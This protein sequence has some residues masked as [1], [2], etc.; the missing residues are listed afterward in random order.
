MK[1]VALCLSGHVRNIDEFKENTLKII[2]TL[3]ADVF[4]STWERDGVGCVFWADEGV[5]EEGLADIDY[6]KEIYNP[7]KIIVSKYEEYEELSNQFPGSF[8]NSKF[9]SHINIKNTLLMFTKFKETVDLVK[10]YEEKNNFKYDMVI[11]GRFDILVNSIGEEVEPNTVYCKQHPD[12][13]IS[14][15]AFF[16][17]D[18][19]TITK[20]TIDK[21]FYTED[22]IN[23]AQNSE[24]IFTKR[25]QS[26]GVNINICDEITYVLRGR[27]Y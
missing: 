27:T 23:S 7:K 10:E 9:A 25:A 1:K 17:A 13:R 26:S 12:N 5:T 3:N 19:D 24:D 22:L 2:E 4:I 11:R 8:P 14:D 18:S 20:L 6:V 15:P 21:N 16:Y